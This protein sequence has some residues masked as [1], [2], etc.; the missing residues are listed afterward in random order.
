MHYSQQV[1]AITEQ[2]AHITD[3]MPVTAINGRK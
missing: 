1:P 2:V 3:D